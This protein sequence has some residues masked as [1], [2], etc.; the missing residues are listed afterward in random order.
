M[1]FKTCN[2]RGIVCSS[3][4]AFIA[5]T[6][7]FNIMGCR[8]DDPDMALSR[9][10]SIFQA[11][12]TD[13]E[14]QTNK[15]R[16]ELEEGK[17]TFLTFGEAI[18]IAQDRDAEFAKVYSKWRRVE[19]EV[20]KIHDKFENLV[21][22]AD[23]FMDTLEFRANSITDDKGRERSSSRLNE[24]KDKYIIQLRR[25]KERINK[26]NEVTTAVRDTMT[27]LEIHYTLEI[28]DE[29]I[30]ETFKEIDTMIAATMV[31]LNELL[32]ESNSLLELRFR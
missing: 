23:D 25:S 20:K 32:I 10:R 12:I 30:L 28:L 2:W 7:F 6:F 24:S 3:L 17:N 14:T 5:M 22:G 4:S 18:K 9:A 29:R 15:V 16:A 8:S 31:Q 19:S 27:E 21:K 11:V 1:N 26:L 13:F